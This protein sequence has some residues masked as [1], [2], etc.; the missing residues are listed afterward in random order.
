MPNSGVSNHSQVYI[1]SV[2]CWL[3]FIVNYWNYT[4]NRFVLGKPQN[5]RFI[6][7]FLQQILEAAPSIIYCLSAD[8][9]EKVVCFITMEINI[10]LLFDQPLK[11][12]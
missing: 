3:S 12:A 4:A 7:L 9:D 2:A 5:C 10:Q 1:A 11:I 8:S 6:I